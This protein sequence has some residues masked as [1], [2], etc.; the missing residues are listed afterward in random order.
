MTAGRE[1]RLL[2]VGFVTVA[3]NG[4]EITSIA[5]GES[6]EPAAPS[7][8]TAR[9]FEQLEAYF[10]GRLQV[11][12]LPLEPQG[13]PFQRRVWAA[14]QTIPYGETRSYGEI[15]RQIGC[16]GG[17]RAVGMANNRNPINIVIPCHRVIGADGKLVGY[18]GGLSIKEALLRLEGSL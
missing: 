5:Y 9:V 3:D 8:L 6:T 16:P 4:T 11:F 2:P 12:D 13:T 10:A 15:A 18:G 17:A 7:A 14:L 1:T